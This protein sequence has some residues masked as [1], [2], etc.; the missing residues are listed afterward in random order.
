MNNEYSKEYVKKITTDGSGT[1]FI[2]ENWNNFLLNYSC[3]PNDELFPKY[4]TG[5]VIDEDKSVKWNREEVERRIK[6]REEEVKRLNREKAEINKL[7]EEGIKARLAKEYDLSLEEV[8][9]IWNHAYSEEHS[10]GLNT[11]YTYFDDLASL[12]DDLK[13]INKS[14]KRN[15]R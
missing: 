3:R 6:S 14:K 11:V 7:Y 15:R 13:K 1:S 4:R 9:L 12:Y 10:S 2:I 5:D 8:E